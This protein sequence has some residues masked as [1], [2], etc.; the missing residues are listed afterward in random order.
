MRGRSDSG[1]TWRPFQTRKLKR[2]AVNLLGGRAPRQE[3]HPYLA[4]ELGE[5][6]HLESALRLGMEHGILCLPV[7]EFLRGVDP[8]SDLTNLLT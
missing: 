2:G 8:A 4:C 6:F 7:D 5:D 3:M 1:V